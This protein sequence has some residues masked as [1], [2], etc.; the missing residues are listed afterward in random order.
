VEWPVLVQG[1]SEFTCF[2]CCLESFYFFA[3]GMH[4]ELLSVPHPG[5]GRYLK[6]SVIIGK[7]TVAGTDASKH[8]CRRVEAAHVY[9]R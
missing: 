4:P 5:S 9:L 3:R 1:S 8:A 2:F 7:V 6:I